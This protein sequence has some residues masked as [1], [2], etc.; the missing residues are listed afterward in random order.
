MDELGEVA[1]AVGVA[2]SEVG[3]R[4]ALRPGGDI[5]QDH[6]ERLLRRGWLLL[7]QGGADRRRD[8]KPEGLRDLLPAVAALGAGHGLLREQ[9]AQELVVGRR[10]PHGLYGV[11]GR[12]HAEEVRARGGDGQEPLD[13]AL[14]P[15]VQGEKHRLP[16]PSGGRLAGNDAERATHGDQVEALGPQALARFLAARPREKREVLAAKRVLRPRPRHDRLN[17]GKYAP[18]VHQ[19]PPSARC[20]NIVRPAVSFS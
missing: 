11:R 17:R 5:G 15:E 12:E 18:A 4:H 6:G 14:G 3:E 13:E 16:L 1:L 7:G 8:C 20:G 2:L 10:H 19:S 9:V